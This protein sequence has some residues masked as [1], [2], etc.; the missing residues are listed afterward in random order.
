MTCHAPLRFTNHLVTNPKNRCY[1]KIYTMWELLLSNLWKQLTKEDNLTEDFR[2]G[3]TGQ[4]RCKGPR[5]A[6]A[7]LQNLVC[8]CRTLKK[9]LEYYE[10]HLRDKTVIRT[11]VTQHTTAQFKPV[12]LS[13]GEN[14]LTDPGEGQALCRSPTGSLPSSNDTE[15]SK[16]EW[17]V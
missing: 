10:R 14:C 2:D 11:I 13:P 5:Q 15:R 6:R 4:R 8:G 1:I 3:T 9:T 17:H 12:K 7:G 16:N